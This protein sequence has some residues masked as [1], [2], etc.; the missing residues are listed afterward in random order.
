MKPKSA[1]ATG[2]RLDQ[3][4]AMLD[5]LRPGARLTP[6]MRAEIAAVLQGL[7]DEEANKR[8]RGHPLDHEKQYEAFCVYCLVEQGIQ[9]K[10]AACTVL[11]RD[12]SAK[13]VATLEARYRT[14]LR[15][16][17]LPGDWSMTLPIPVKEIESLPRTSRTARRTGGK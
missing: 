2:S 1:K 9:L 11:G 3:L 16:G 4:T 10:A 15:A 5:A 6:A 7:W 14:M 17:Q 8:G 12:A 13:D